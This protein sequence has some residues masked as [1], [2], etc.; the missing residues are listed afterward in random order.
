[1]SGSFAARDQ[2]AARAEDLRAIGHKVQAGWLSEP[3]L[4]ADDP[5]HA[6][7]E[8][9]ARANDDVV[10]ITVTEGIVVNTEWPS[11]SGGL[12]TEKWF[13]KYKGSGRL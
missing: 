7:W 11:T 8:R 5:D 6:Q 13:N 1:M 2:L 10:D 12:H 3:P 9:R 4:S